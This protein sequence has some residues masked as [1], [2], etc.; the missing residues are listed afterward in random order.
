MKACPSFPGYS[1]T[2]DGQVFSHRKRKRLLGSQGGTEVFIAPEY[3]RPCKAYKQA[4]GYLTVSISNGKRAR[5]VGI[6][7]LVADSY[8][9]PALPGQQVR[10]LDGNPANNTRS[11]LAYGDALQNAGDRL[12]HGRYAAGGTHINAKLTQEQAQQIRKLRREG[13]KVKELAA[14]FQVSVS[15]VASIIYNK[16]YV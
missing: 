4:K 9:S 11:N 13:R 8:I 3:V 10:H 15:T 16:S 5:P 1:V 12:A 2:E 6:H 7:Q 14:Q